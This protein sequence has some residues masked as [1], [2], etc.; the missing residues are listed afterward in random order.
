VEQHKRRGSFSWARLTGNGDS[1]TL[2]PPFT[3]EV[4]ETLWK[5]GGKLRNIV[6]TLCF[7]TAIV[8]ATLDS[9]VHFPEGYPVIMD[10]KLALS[11]LPH[12]ANPKAYLMRELQQLCGNNFQH[13]LGVTGES[14][15]L[16][17]V[18]RW[19]CTAP[20][21]T[22]PNKMVG[23]SRL[24]WEGRDGEDGGVHVGREKLW[25]HELGNEDTEGSINTYDILIGR[26][27]TG[28]YSSRFTADTE[29]VRCGPHLMPKFRC[30]KAKQRLI[31]E[32]EAA[33]HDD[34]CVSI[35]QRPPQRMHAYKTYIDR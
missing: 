6:G 23:G 32:R 8:S 29:D 10:S 20:N 24:Q 22:P 27:R 21:P 15:A 18:H 9:D 13:L 17:S 34:E 16:Q 3:V 31:N 4:K 12:Y 30:C 26:G 11:I 35:R 14:D 2:R 7:H 19:D 5:K 25:R 1:V 28:S 33:R